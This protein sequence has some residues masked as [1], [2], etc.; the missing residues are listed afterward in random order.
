MFIWVRERGLCRKCK[1]LEIYEMLL[2]LLFTGRYNSQKILVHASDI[3]WGIKSNNAF[4]GWLKPDPGGRGLLREK[5][6]GGVRPASQN[7]YPIYDQNL[8][9]SLP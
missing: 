8:R 4:V 1:L 3:N 5:L 7:P 9:Y 2:K 6:G